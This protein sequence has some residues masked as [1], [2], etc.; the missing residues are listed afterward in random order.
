MINYQ[1]LIH[2]KEGVDRP[3]WGAGYS[4]SQDV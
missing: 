3:G 2:Y 1:A 4:E